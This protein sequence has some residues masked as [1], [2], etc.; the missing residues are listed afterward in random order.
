MSNR[1]SDKKSL[2]NWAKDLGHRFRRPHNAPNVASSSPGI[3]SVPDGKSGAIS[4]VFDL[5]NIQNDCYDSAKS[6]DGLQASDAARRS[7]PSQPQGLADSH[8]I[9]S[10]YELLHYSVMD[11]VFYRPSDIYIASSF[12]NYIVFNPSFNSRIVT[13]PDECPNMTFPSQT[14]TQVAR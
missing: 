10:I 4:G 8:M 1:K 2:L 3:A 6:N 7:N 11:G 12:L 9:I 5:T 13:T 14:A